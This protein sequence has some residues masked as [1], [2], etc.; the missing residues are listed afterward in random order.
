MKI[1]IGFDFK[2]FPKT[3]GWMIQQLLDKWRDRER[4]EEDDESNLSQWIGLPDY[5]NGVI[6]K[7][8]RKPV[9]FFMKIFV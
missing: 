8:M 2:A 4:E 5:I 6:R 1:P 9:E 7:F 3:R